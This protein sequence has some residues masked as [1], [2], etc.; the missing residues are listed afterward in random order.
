MMIF[1]VIEIGECIGCVQDLFDSCISEDDFST[2]LDLR[3]GTYRFYFLVDE[4]KRYSSEYPTV[5][6]S[7]GNLINYVEIPEYGIRPFELGEEIPIPVGSPP[8]DIVVTDLDTFSQIIPHWDDV[9][10]VEEPPAL[11]PHLGEIMLNRE[12]PMDSDRS[13]LQ[14]PHHV[15]LHHLYALSIRD[16]IMVLATTHRY[17]RKYITVVY[18][19]PVIN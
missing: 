5:L 9:G 11:P 8:G 16:G 12:P 13:V 17:K 15:G 6:D 14:V 1:M 19:K 18:Y 3:P 2:V 10:R 4:E 7:D